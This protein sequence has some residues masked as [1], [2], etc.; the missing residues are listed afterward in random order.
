MFTMH[1]IHKI[2]KLHLNIAIKLSF[3]IILLIIWG[4]FLFVFLFFTGSFYVGYLLN[5]IQHLLVDGFS[6]A[7]CDFGALTGGNGCMS[8]YSPF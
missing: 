6:I 3:K 4:F 1:K 5:R 8:F 2:M 7:S